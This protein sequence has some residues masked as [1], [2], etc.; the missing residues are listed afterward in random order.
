MSTEI[1]FDVFWEWAVGHFGEY[2][3]VRHGDEVCINS[4]FVA[5]YKADTGNHMWCNPSKGIYHCWKSDRSGTL[6]H[7]VKEM[8]GCTYPEAVDILGDTAALRT[9]NDRLTKYLAVNKKQNVKTPDVKAG[10]LLQLPQ[11]TF[12]ISDLAPDNGLRRQAEAYLKD[13]HIPAAGLHVCAA[14][15]YANR[16]IIPYYGPNGNL[17]YFNGRDLTGRSK[18][19]YQ[20]PP[21]EVGVGKSDVIWIK[22][23]PKAGTKLYLTEGEFDAMSLWEAEYCGAALGGKNL[24]PK[25]FKLLEPYEVTICFDLDKSG[26][27]ALNKVSAYMRSNSGRIRK[28]GYV[29]PAKNFKD[30][31]DMLMKIGSPALH[32]YIQTQEKSLESWQELVNLRFET[33]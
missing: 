15:R 4:P 32:Y 27:E 7:L 26:I 18:L 2:N 1:D 25:Q 13:R 12:L 21:K 24:S 20:G 22:S 29:K 19:R 10:S 8:V 33:F 16:I 5:D 11:D 14:G 9:L 6:Y 31:N 30:W 3:V 17:I 23:W 28:V